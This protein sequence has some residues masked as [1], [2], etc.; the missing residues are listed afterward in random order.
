MKNCILLKMLP[1]AI[2]HSATNKKK[3]LIFIELVDDS[4]LW[5]SVTSFSLSISC[6]SALNFTFLFSQLLRDGSEWNEK[7]V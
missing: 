6:T 3:F 7:T 1:R 5:L 4:F 2:N